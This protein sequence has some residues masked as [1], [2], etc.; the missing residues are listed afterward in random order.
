M[1]GKSRINVNEDALNVSL[2]IF[3]DEYAR[4]GS[5]ADEMALGYNGKS[6]IRTARLRVGSI[7]GERD[8]QNIGGSLAALRNG[9]SRVQIGDNAS[10][11][12]TCSVTNA[13]RAHLLAVKRFL[14]GN[15][16]SDRSLRVDGEALFITD[17]QLLP[18]WT[19]QRM[20]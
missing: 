8:R 9:A 14:E 4:S 11:Y 13:A 6:G 16:S 12:D 18:F 19:F 1:A 20:I 10:L 15:Y 7:Y 3:N 17:G 2:S 5:M